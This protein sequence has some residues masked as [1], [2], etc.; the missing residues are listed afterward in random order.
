MKKIFFLCTIFIFAHCADK[1][2]S[3]ENLKS[4][5]DCEKFPLQYCEWKN[6]N[7]VVS[8]ESTLNPV[9]EGKPFC[10]Q[11]TFQN[12]C[13]KAFICSNCQNKQQFCQGCLKQYPCVWEG[14]QCLFFTG[15]TVYP[16]KTHLEC[17]AISGECT[18]DLTQCIEIGECTEYNTQDSCKQKNIHGQMC[19]WDPQLGCKDLSSCSEIQKEFSTSHDACNSQ[20]SKCTVNNNAQCIDLFTECGDYTFEDQCKLTSSKVQCT[21]SNNACRETTCEDAPL[22]Y[23]SSGR[24]QLF[25]LNCI[26]KSG[27][28]CQ[29]IIYCQDLKNQSDCL[30]K[31]DV[32]GKPCYW[33]VNQSQ[34]VLHECEKAPLDYQTNKQC[35][36]FK[37]DCIANEGSGCKQNKGCSA[38]TTQLECNTN[39]SAEGKDCMWEEVCIEKTCENASTKLTT[40]EQCEKFL[41]ECTTDYGQGCQQKTCK[42]APD[43]MKTN[44][45]CERYLPDNHCITRSGG[46]CVKN[47]SCSKVSVAIACVKD[48]NGSD[49][50]WYEATDVCITKQCNKAPT[51]I[52]TQAKCEA[53]WFKCQVNASGTGCEDKICENYQQESKCKSQLDF[54]GR[55]C[56]WRNKCIEKTCESASDDIKTHEDCNN[57]LSTCT[58]SL[59]GK[60]CMSLPL[61]CEMILLE[62][63]CRLRSSIGLNNVVGTK[64]CAWK[65]NKCQDK[66]CYTAPITRDSNIACQ[67]YMKGC[68]VNNERK[69]CWI[70][71]ECS[72]RALQETCE[73]SGNN[74]CVWDQGNSKCLVKNCVSTLY[75]SDRANYITIQSCKQYK[76]NAANCPKPDGIGCC[77]LND[78]GLGCM[79][80]PDTCSQLKTQK[81]C[82]ENA[83]STD[84]DCIWTGEACVAKSCTAL[85]LKIYNQVYSHTNCYSY[86]FQSCTVNENATACIPLKS[87]CS[88]YLPNDQCKKDSNGNDCALRF[89]SASKILSCDLEKCIDKTSKT[90]NSFAACQGYNETCTVIARVNGKG[91]VDRQ[92]YCFNYKNQEQC[93]KNL[94]QQKCI[95]NDSRCWDYD[96]VECSQLKLNNYSTQT[97]EDVVTYCKAN[98]D[99]TGCIIKT[100]VDYNTQT[101]KIGGPQVLLLSHCQAII[102]NKS[103]CSINKNLNACVVEQE[104]CSQYQPQDC[105]YA[106][107]DGICKTNGTLC[108]KQ[109]YSCSNWSSEN[110][111]GCKINREFCKYPSD[112][113]GI[114][115]C[116]NRS[117]EEKV[118]V[119][120]T[121]EICYQFDQTCTVNKDKTKCIL[122]QSNC[123]T[124]KEENL[125]IKSTQSN[126]IWQVDDTSECVGITNLTEAIKNCSYK[127][128]VGL[129]YNDCQAFSP[130][131]SINR[132]QDECVAKQQCGGYS[133][134]HCYRSSEIEFCIQTKVEDAESECASPANKSCEQIFLGQS[135]V[136]TLEKCSQINQSCTNQGTSGCTLK[137][138]QNAVGPFTHESCVAWKST[139]TVKQS[140]DGCQEMKQKCLDQESN[141]CLITLFDG[142][143]VQDIKQNLCVKK[144]CYSSDDTLTSDAQCEQY[145]S[146]CTVA[147]VGGCIPRSTCDAYITELQCIVD[148]QDRICFWNP[149]IQ[150]CVLFECKSIEKT[151]K[152]DTHEECYQL[153][154]IQDPKKQNKFQRCT[155]NL[156]QDANDKTILN[157]SG[158]MNLLGCHEYKYKEQCFIDSSGSYCKWNTDNPE[159]EFCEQTTCLSADPNSYSTHQA[160]TEY[161][162]NVNTKYQDKCTVAVIELA[163]G[164]LQAQGCRYRAD[165]EEYKIEDQCRY[166]S[167]GLECKWDT[168]DQA[169]FTRL[170]S[171]APKTITTHE[172]CS[173][174]LSSCTL[175]SNLIGCMDL[176]PK[177]EDYQVKSQCTKS[178]YGNLCYWNGIQCVTRLCSN[179]PEDLNEECSSYLDTCENSGN[180]RC[181]TVDCQQY[182]FVTDLAC[183][184]AGLGGKCTT[185]GIRC[186]LRK[187]CEEARTQDA[188]R[189]NDLGQ[190]CI[191]NPPTATSDGYCEI[192]ICE[193]ASQVDFVS[194]LQCKS[195]HSGCTLKKTG[196]CKQIQ[197]CNSF[198]TEASCKISKDG[199]VCVWE[200]DKGCRSND[201]NDLT[202]TDH[203]KCKSQNKICTT[204]KTG[205]CVNM[206]ASCAEYQIEGSCVET[207]DGFPCLWVKALQNTNNPLGQCIQYLKCEDIPLTTDAECKSVFPNCTSNGQTCTP[208]KKCENLNSTNCKKGSDGQ[209][210]LALKEATSTTKTCMLFKQCSDALYKTHSECQGVSS[211]CTTSGTQCMELKQNCSDYSDRS[212]CYITK[213]QSNNSSTNTGICVWDGVCRNQTC[214]DISGTTHNYCNSKMNTCTSD[215]TKCMT[216]Q[217]CA[218]YNTNA[219]CNYGYEKSGTEF[220]PCYW[221]DVSK[222]S[223]SYCRVKTCADILPASSF[224]CAQISTCVYDATKQSCIIK[225]SSCG[226]YQDQNACNSG[227][228]NSKNCYWTN[229]SCSEVTGCQIISDQAKCLSLKGCSYITQNGTSQCLPS[230]CQKVYQQTNSCKFY[231]TFSNTLTTCIIQNG[232]CKSVPPSNLNEENCLVNSNY[233]YT[234]SSSKNTCV[235]CI[236]VEPPPS[237]GSNCTEPENCDDS[238]QKISI[239]LIFLAM[240]F[241]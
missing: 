149:S 20:L 169:C 67:E 183:K 25:M 81:N 198:E 209:C 135:T 42:N 133:L 207:S 129:T 151:D 173:D 180:L 165:C 177:C 222:D 93:Y 204:S 125:C 195:Y 72:Q 31:L 143:C 139:C 231:E 74:D 150:K 100:C 11:Y 120:L 10:S 39:K 202:G 16:K 186:V 205:K 197:D 90:F 219:K 5:L 47:D 142:I 227:A 200:K 28:G 223:G 162:L 89:N 92:Q 60:G 230:D 21:W 189:V 13:Q 137:T 34:C 213:A 24:C 59:I 122:I 232:E 201:C 1:Q 104:R 3:C 44:E 112:G 108:Y 181:V 239:G 211:N 166:S 130:F 43:T 58:L 217:T 77:T 94:A 208:I 156:I 88:L 172:R 154:N 174:F 110:D 36:S 199:K 116:E 8:N 15:C 190:Q 9:I 237:N 185:D 66:T 221:T 23:D 215:G 132:A 194:E 37:S 97:C 96:K 236:W 155:V 107:I 141:N 57:Y 2:C 12:D 238:A 105:Y 175:S 49:C 64:E 118:G 188:C 76:L 160:C 98:S 196:G 87:S 147:Q 128:G 48:I 52:N 106:S 123:G 124:Y 214:P 45:D 113:V 126:C 234:W 119:N 161:Q 51:T 229:N 50:Q 56:S 63:G 136:Y 225:Q 240:I 241:G 192:S 138:C 187:S 91:C 184:Q 140:K 61:K 115:A 65:G 75:S 109:F 179:T 70:L 218:S 170:C 206:S 191:W 163:P 148:N 62:E 102:A 152:Y 71:P 85:N 144:S 178:V 18:S 26:A 83:I 78:Q 103:K 159:N 53:F 46:G 164:V 111:A 193:L 145:M 19:T 153:N 38:I 14:S 40:H 32:S 4:Q 157:P 220:N 121:E 27:G 30:N 224:F 6:N 176:T 86:S 117:C 22:S 101:G 168:I 131:C 134:S 212:Q 69:G 235:N 84:E 79:K 167:S 127:K 80:K 95:W 54:Y 158:C 55:S 99:N 82:G 233:T 17:N 41:F 171:K 146:T 33:V 228:L 226:S 182:S 7:C 210:M 216:I 73:I 203:F 114:K 29:Q 35:Q 68:Y